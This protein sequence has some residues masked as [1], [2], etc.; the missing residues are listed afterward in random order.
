MSL[1]LRSSQPESKL[2]LSGGRQVSYVMSLVSHCEACDE[3]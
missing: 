2:V 1:V 3:S